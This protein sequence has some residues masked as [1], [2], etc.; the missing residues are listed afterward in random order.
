M[1][2]P[3]GDSLADAAEAGVARGQVFDI[4]EPRL[5]VTGH[6][7]V[8]RACACGYRTTGTAPAE[9][10]APA[11]YGPRLAAIGVYLLHGQFLSVSRTALALRDLFS[12]PVAAGTVVC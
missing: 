3:S 11:V 5:V 12:A 7:I 8:T 4:P 1:C 2:L 9:A 6:Q 10:P